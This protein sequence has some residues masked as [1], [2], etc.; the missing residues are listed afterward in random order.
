[1]TEENM[2]LDF[3]NVKDAS[4]FIG[5]VL[6]AYN[7]V[8]SDLHI[9]ACVAIHQ[10]AAF[11]RCENLGKLYDGLRKNDQVA[12]RI[13]LG[14][15]SAYMVTA[16]NVETKKHWLS[17]DTKAKTSAERWTIRKGTDEMRKASKALTPTTIVTEQAFHIKENNKKNDPF[18]MVNLLA[19][20]KAFIK[21]TKTR[22]DNDDLAIPADLMA[23]FTK[24]EA[25]ASTLPTATKA[26]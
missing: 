2:K 8:A 4:K 7:A 25:I 1:M 3:A 26:A 23:E 14:K 12:L 19:S 16:D 21:R 11:G 17:L 24:L 13:W 10:A 6:V 18:T 20:V 22:A 9:A 5:R 15:Q